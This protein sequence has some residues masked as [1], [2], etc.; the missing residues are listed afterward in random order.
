MIRATLFLLFLVACHPVPRVHAAELPAVSVLQSCTAM[1]AGDMSSGVP[2]FTDA[3]CDK[4]TPGVLAQ[5]IGDGLPCVELISWDYEVGY[6]WDTTNVAC[7]VRGFD[8]LQRYSSEN[9]G[10]F[11]LRGNT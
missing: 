2:G 8:R 9:G 7:R 4:L 11:H 10:K 5:I 1:A 6:H 3:E